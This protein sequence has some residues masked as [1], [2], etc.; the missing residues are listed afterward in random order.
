MNHTTPITDPLRDCIGIPAGFI[1]AA[2]AGGCI[3]LSL[4][5]L[6]IRVFG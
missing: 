2:A 6:A 4:G 1:I 5:M 3:W